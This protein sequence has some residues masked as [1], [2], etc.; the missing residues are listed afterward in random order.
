[1]VVLEFLKSVQK[2][3]KPDFVQPGQGTWHDLRLDF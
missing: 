3:I 2:V 1:M